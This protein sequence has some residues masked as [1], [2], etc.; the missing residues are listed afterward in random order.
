[1]A[2]HQWH[3]TAGNFDEDETEGGGEGVAAAPLSIEDGGLDGGE[4]ERRGAGYRSALVLE[5]AG[6]GDRCRVDCVDMNGRVELA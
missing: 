6:A 1:M 5:G 4:G 2:S 3:S